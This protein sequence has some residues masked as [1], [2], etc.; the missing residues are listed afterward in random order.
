ERLPPESLAAS[1][2]IRGA[3]CVMVTLGGEGVLVARSGGHLHL[4]A[5]RVVAVDSTAAGDAFA[6]AL[7]TAL[8][9]GADLSA[10]TEFAVAAPAVSVTRLGAQPSLPTRPQVEALLREQVT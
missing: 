7:A 1:L 4:P 6:G 2:L 10:A 8:S 5:R 3:P 9:E